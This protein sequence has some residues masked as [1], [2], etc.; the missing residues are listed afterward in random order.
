MKNSN[1]PIPV[2]ILLVAGAYFSNQ[3]KN[4]DILRLSIGLILA[5]TLIYA[6]K[7]LLNIRRKRRLSQSK[8][9]DIDVMSGLEFEK[10]I[11]LL[12]ERKGFSSV[13]LTEHFDLGVDIIATKEG[14]TW[15]IQVKRY[16]GTVKANAVRQAVTALN[17][18]KCSRAMVIT[19]NYFTK[20]AKQLASSNKCVLIDRA[21]LIDLILTTD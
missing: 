19:N 5:I 10:Y 14:V 13:K 8:I 20:Q 11:K 15:G 9:S 18:Y 3:Q 21:K 17:H 4:G 2:L 16:S 1:N 7:L 12:L 6:I